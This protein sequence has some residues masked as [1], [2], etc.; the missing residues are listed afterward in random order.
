MGLVA[1]VVGVGASTMGVAGL[2]YLVGFAYGLVIGGLLGA[3]VI[4]WPVE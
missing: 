1:V 4:L 2:D 3:I